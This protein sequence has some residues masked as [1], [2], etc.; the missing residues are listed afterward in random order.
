[1]EPPFDVFLSYTGRDKPAVREICKLL[2]DR[3]LRPW[4][5]QEQ[6]IP[7]RPW[8]E[9]LAEKVIERIAAA[10]VC[11]SKDGL[12]PW[13]N[14]EMRAYISKFVESD[15]PVI[16]VLLPG[17][18]KKPKLPAFLQ[19]F[20]WVDLRGGLTPEGIDRLVFGITGRNPAPAPGPPSGLL[21]SPL[22]NLPFQ[23][24]GDLFKGRE[25]ELAELEA[26]A[27]S[28]A[29]KKVL[30]G[31]GGIGK[32]CLAVEYAWRH[33]ARYRATFFVRAGSPAE[34]RAQ[35]AALAG[36]DLLHLPERQAAAEEEA[37]FGA[38]LTWL[39]ENPGWLLILDNV[40]T[41][42]AAR[43]VRELLPLLQGGKVLV[44]SDLAAWPAGFGKREVERISREEAARFLLERTQGNREKAAGDP[45]DAVRLA[46]FLDG[47]PLALEQAAAYIAFHHLSLAEYLDAWERTREE[48]N[49][50]DERVMDYPRSLAA[51]WQQTVERLGLAPA[52]L[53]RLMAYLAPDPIPNA[54]FE[55]GEELVAEA[56][57]Q[58]A[59]ET[60]QPPKREPVSVA[61]GN[62]AAYSMIEQEDGVVV[63]H[64]L[65]QEVTRTRIPAE[66]QRAWI[67]LALRLVDHFAPEPPDDV[68]TWP[69][70]DL[71][72]PHAAVVLAHAEAAGLPEPTG[73]LMNELGALLATK[74]LFAEAEGLYR[75]A[76]DIGQ[77]AFG[78]DDPKVASYLNN[79]AQLLKATNRLAEAEPLMRRALEI[80]QAAFGGEHPNVAEDLNNLAGL[81]Q[82]TNRFDEAEPFMR[83]AL[84]ID[85][86]AFGN[87]HPR[88]AV[89][90]NDLAS[91][92]YATN[93]LAEAAPL[94]RRALEIDQAVFGN[95]HPRIAVRLNNMAGL[96]QATNRLA[97][98]EPFM[99]RA[100]E[101]DQA[102]F[103][104]D[105][106][107]VARDLNNLAQLLQDTNRMDE[108]EPLLRRALDIDQATFG[109]D[110]P[111]VARDLNNLASLLRATNRL[112]EAEP[113]I[114]R[115]LEMDQA[116]FG[117]DHPTIAIR[118]NNLALLLQA[119][120]RLAEAEPLMRRALEIDQAAFGEN[121]PNIAIDLNNLAQLLQ[122]TNRLAEAE[123]LM[124]R[125]LEIFER[126]FGPDY[127]STK[128]AR[129]NLENLLA[130]QKGVG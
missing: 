26:F 70:W 93:R 64:R 102:A 99:R 120:N 84:E 34:L 11:V 94:M 129:T 12:G 28:S 77:V 42:D 5:D 24:L 100:L 128:I 31:L 125:A 108:A 95:D 49:W 112:H 65:V 104:N 81:L 96:L 76:L 91:L 59:E 68:R 37:V 117:H 105:H 113:F 48:V 118:L 20:T 40:N 123:P 82:A 103:G 124:R 8:Q 83:R 4:L 116:S 110:H 33:G 119:T 98:A 109:N 121:H 66:Q 3:G 17:A 46:A 67:E 107:S 53:L 72:R 85:Q 30:Y 23:S 10:A 45:A 61:L 14:R 56:I 50:Y 80:D 32:T 43:A 115:A 114:R 29:Q 21:P 19:A 87:D 44:T 22:H 15:R 7:G 1:M 54:L 130:S 69:V 63:V 36:P 55:S 35:V 90:L 13:E 75:R 86:A 122:A 52:A 126:S 57:R 78:S 60:S 25:A 106:P 16:P 47:L 41:G 9:A 88:I 101:I 6:L 2:R 27:A 18:A 97:E 71:L 92:L 74:G 51:T 58:L 73:R 62:L 127:P 38:V 111:N 79:L 89:R 39:R